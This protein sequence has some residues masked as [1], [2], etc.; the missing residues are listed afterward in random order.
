MKC[1][2]LGFRN[3]DE[4]IKDEISENYVC[5]KC[6]KYYWL[7]EN[8]SCGK[9]VVTK[10][11]LNNKCI[12]CGDSQQGGI[13]GCY[14]CLTNEKGSGITCKQCTDNYIL[15]SDD[16]KCKK[17]DEQY[18][19]FDSC[20]E[21]K[22]KN[23]NYVCS[24]CKL[25]YSLIEI[26]GELKCIE[27]PTLYDQD[28]NVYYYYK[29]NSNN[30]YKGKNLIN[31]YSYKQNFFYPCKESINLGT[32]ANPRYS[33]NKCY[34]VFDNEEFDNIYY[35]DYDDYY[36]YFY[37]NYYD[38]Y[39]YDYYYLE[40]EYY[41]IYGHPIKITEIIEKGEN[42]NYCMV[43][44]QDTENCLEA[45]YKIENGKEIYDCQKCNDKY[46]LKYDKY[47]KI[48]YC[49]ENKNTAIRCMVNF[50]KNC[51]SDNYYF[52]S[53]CITSDYEVNKITGSCVKKMEVIPTVT[54]KD[55]FKLLMNDEKVI[56]G[57]TISGPSLI[58]RGITSSQI[59]SRHAFLIYL[60]FKIKYSLRNLQA[61]K[62]ITTYCEIKESVEESKDDINLI[63]YECI[64]DSDVELDNNTY[65]LIGIEEGDKD[66]VIISNSFDDI[67]KNTNLTNL[68][69]KN[70]P[71]FTIKDLEHIIKLIVDENYI[72]NQT[73]SNNTFNFSL[74][75]RLNINLESREFKDLELKLRGIENETAKCNF[76][77]EDNSNASLIC[78]LE[79]KSDYEIKNFS[80]KTDELDL[81][82][83]E[84]KLY[85]PSLNE[86][87]LLKTEEEISRE[88]KR[89]RINHNT[90][91]A[92]LSIVVGA[93]AL[94]GIGIVLYIILKPT[95][96]IPVDIINTNNIAE[97]STKKIN[98]SDANL[99]K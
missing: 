9:C 51:I 87:Y 52:C 96:V 65:E 40:D 35:N 68:E 85:V 62:I 89:A 21:L 83:K 56:N 23:G 15:L 5:T 93:L 75:G 2:D 95:R 77:S 86:I 13:E 27:T 37:Y 48:N 26:D 30:E 70:N 34:N 53:S 29:L 58:L 12:Q 38:D 14:Y 73:S 92:V 36:K 76:N 17:R 79:L 6:S 10:A 20:L 24:K 59:N 25:R 71:D 28:F 88:R 63:D 4:C 8:G 81:K 46:I 97:T 94:A 22:I 3:C 31:N 49:T 45:T 60:T 41:L 91:I 74:Y 18:K 57:K 99:N 80:F 44:N 90:L 84:K 55:I 54:W 72:N 16:N 98:R 61:V 7:N 1:S 69:R 66:G 33:C 67:V 47:L 43:P 32:K 82:Y 64:G 78:G 42:I 19:K 50:C 39:Y 11:E